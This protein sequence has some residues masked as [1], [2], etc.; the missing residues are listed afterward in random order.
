MVVLAAGEVLLLLVDTGYVD[1]SELE[2]CTIFQWESGGYSTHVD[3]LQVYLGFFT[4]F[5]RIV[6]KLFWCY[7]A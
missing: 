4:L 7:S 6:L 3:R 1:F 2:S 5:V